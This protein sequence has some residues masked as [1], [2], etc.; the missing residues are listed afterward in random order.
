MTR[1]YGIQAHLH[2]QIAARNMR[3]LFVHSDGRDDLIVPDVGIGE[4]AMPSVTD[5]IGALTVGSGSEVPSMITPW[6]R[7]TP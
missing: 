4:N 6:P 5:G 2:Y 3:P 7:F 1:L